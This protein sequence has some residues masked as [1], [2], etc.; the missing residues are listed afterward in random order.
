MGLVTFR[1][2]AVAA[3]LAPRCIL[4]TTRMLVLLMVAVDVDARED[5]PAHAV[6]PVFSSIFSSLPSW[7]TPRPLSW[8]PR[9]LIACSPVTREA[10]PTRTLC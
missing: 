6:G 9:F 5:G 8:V 4:V 1:W 2:P 10:E 3:G 7:S